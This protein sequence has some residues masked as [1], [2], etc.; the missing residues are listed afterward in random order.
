MALYVGTNYHPHDWKPERWEKDIELMKK[1]GLKVVRLGHLCWDS[2]EPE[3]GRYTFEWFDEVM[4]D[5]NEAEIKVILD[6]SMRPAPIWVHKLCPGCD[7]YSKSE[8]RQAPLRRYMEDVD[9]PDYQFYALRFA[10]IIV[11]RYKDHPALMGFG[12]CNELGDGF[13]SYSKAAQKRF[14]EWLKKKYTTVET[15]NQKWNTQ[16]W[17]RRLPSFKDVEL[18]ENEISKGSPE[19]FLDMRRFYG[20]GVLEFMKKLKRVVE[21]EAPG[22]MHSSNHVAE[23][24]YLG[25]DYLKG[26]QEFV[27]YPGFGFYPNLDPAD[28]NT[29]MYVLMY[30]QHRLGELGKPMWC[31]EFQ[32]GNF[33]CYAGTDGI[34][35]MYALLCLAYRTQMVLAWT[36]R[37]MLGGEEQF[38]FGLL[39]HD[40]TCGRKYDEFARIASDYKKLEKYNLPYLPE[41]EAA[42]AYCYENLPIYDYAPHYY[43]TPYKQQAADTFKFFYRKNLDFNIVDL[44]NMK[45]DY[46][47]LII[48][49]HAIMTEEMVQNLKSFIQ[50]GGIAVM[51]A[52]SAKVDGNN[53]VFDTPQPGLLSE[54]FG[55]RIGEFGRTHINVVIKPEKIPMKHFRIEREDG[56]SVCYEASYWENIELVTAKSYAIYTEGEEGCGVSVNHYGRGKAYYVSPEANTELLGW[57]YDKIADEHGLKKGIDAP[58]GVVVR[59]LS[60]T[61]TF[62]VN[63]TEKTKE[64][65]IPKEVKGVLS[66]T[67]ITDKLILKPYDG[68]LIVS[69]P[70]SVKK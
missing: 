11:R 5:F 21:Q 70:H 17:S 1:A 19:A 64:I 59:Q 35:R 62:F 47:I 40:G 16:R 37:S 67:R 33:G 43:R 10:G 38:Y 7:I 14:Q 24:D 15:L 65:K 42:I 56:E 57:L 66:K 34:I 39:D 44:R 27:D 51:T 32:T 29:L 23:G 63:T 49:G 3:D 26:C 6:V 48:P 61:E 55:I 4:D 45:K 60:E 41:P 9:D 18:P 68:E 54:A 58:E 69:E 22:I 31:L 52:Y 8:I 46:K 20:D 53:T 25:F 28:E 13:V 2:Y 30:M 50:D 12:L 36:W